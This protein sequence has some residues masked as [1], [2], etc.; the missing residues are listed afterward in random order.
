MSNLETA[1]LLLAI[2]ATAIFFAIVGGVGWTDN[3][4]AAPIPDRRE[5][6]HARR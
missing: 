6:R 3:R 1:H 2:W 4:V 5:A